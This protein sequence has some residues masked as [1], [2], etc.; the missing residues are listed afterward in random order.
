MNSLF[1]CLLGQYYLTNLPQFR[2]DAAIF[3]AIGLFSFW[4]VLVRV[5]VTTSP[6]PRPDDAPFEPI[7]QRWPLAVLLCGV[8]G[9]DVLGLRQQHFHAAGRAGLAGRCGAF[10]GG[11]VAPDPHPLPSPVCRN[12][13]RERALPSASD[14]ARSR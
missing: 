8:G 13:K 7:S 10:P 5:G 3:Y 4:R 9:A 12:R 11:D 1:W 2:W 6:A 14:G